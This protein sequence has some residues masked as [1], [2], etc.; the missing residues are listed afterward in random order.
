LLTG[1]N[2]LVTTVVTLTL[3]ILI[4]QGITH[5]QDHFSSPV[6]ASAG[7]AP[8][9]RGVFALPGATTDLDRISPYDVVPAIRTRGALP[10]GDQDVSL[11]VRGNASHTVTITDIRAHV[12]NVAPPFTGTLLYAPPQGESSSVMIGIELSGPSL[13]ARDIAGESKFLGAHFDQHPYT[14]RND[15]IATFGIDAHASGGLY[16][17]D[18]ALELVVDGVRQVV[19]VG[20]PNGPFRVTSLSNHYQSVIIAN[21]LT[22]N[23]FAT[24]DPGDFCKQRPVCEDKPR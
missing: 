13:S 8:T 17:W 21:R 4:P 20:G 2:I 19:N 6:E 14:L 15:E 24:T 12:L 5:L 10:A 3:G 11:V 9:I 1:K 7:I 22:P 18:I 23:G 16:S